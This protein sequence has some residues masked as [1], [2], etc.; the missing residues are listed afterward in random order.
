MKILHIESGRH[1]Y[2]GPRQVMLLIEGLR[3]AGHVNV[4]ACPEGSEIGRRS[5]GAQIV[6]MPMRGDLDVPLVLRLRR[7]LRQTQP[8]I[9]HL[10]SRRG[11]DWWGAV[12][13][14]RGRAPVVLSRRVD[15][16]EPALLA[17]I[18]YAM[19]DRVIAISMRIRDVLLDAGVPPAKIVCVRSAVPRA[20]PGIRD[21]AWFETVFGVEPQA[22]AIGMIAQLIRRK[23]HRYLLD[24]LPAIT[25]AHPALRVLLFGQGALENE[26]RA[27]AA[28]LGLARNVIFAGFR[29]DLERILPNLDLVVHPAL[30]EGLGVAVL[31]AAQAGLPIVASRV[32][33][34]PEIVRDAATGLLVPPG[35]SAALGA[36]IVGLLDDR[37]L[38]LSLGS[39]AAERVALE[40]G[41]DAM[42]AGNLAVYEALLAR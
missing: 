40:F 13:A 34:L 3:A 22:P 6:R 5:E 30:M 17:K 31:Q 26:L 38:A 37:R 4:L 16:P 1:L 28:R 35:D 41:V 19:V 12:A 10:H 39:A 11:A 8:D 36:A 42:V 7:L 14:H 9:V 15:N 33:G 27:H 32:G 2:G 25:A 18:K 23:G 21:R 24:A 20:R 29:D